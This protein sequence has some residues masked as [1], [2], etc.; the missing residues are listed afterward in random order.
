MGTCSPEKNR[1]TNVSSTP[2]PS[3]NHNSSLMLQSCTMRPR[4]KLKFIGRVQLRAASLCS[5]LQEYRRPVAVEPQCPWNSDLFIAV[6]PSWKW[7]G[8]A[9][10]L[11]CLGQILRTERSTNLCP[12]GLPLAFPFPEPAGQLFAGGSELTAH[13]FPGLVTCVF[14]VHVSQVWITAF[15]SR[16]IRVTGSWCCITLRT[17]GW[18]EVQTDGLL[19]IR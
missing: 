15:G 3:L 2:R 7:T 5:G 1:L 16:S 6:F 19:D 13:T 9:C 12:P 14:G 10:Q 11:P 4:S 8:L 18:L 17:G